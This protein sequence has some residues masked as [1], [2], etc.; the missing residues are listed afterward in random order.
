M[1]LRDPTSGVIDTL[2]T[3]VNTVR[4]NAVFKWLNCDLLLHTTHTKWRTKSQTTLSLL[5][6]SFKVVLCLFQDPNILINCH[7][8]ICRVGQ[9]SLDYQWFVT[10]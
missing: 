2:L 3:V 5:Y 1:S 9:P 10:C 8:A 4:D 6:P 7:A